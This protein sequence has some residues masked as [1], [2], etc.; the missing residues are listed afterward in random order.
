MEHAFRNVLCFQDIVS[1]KP[2]VIS[3]YMGNG[4]LWSLSYE[5]WFYIIFVLSEKIKP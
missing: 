2:N 4:V 1:L 5:W 3:A